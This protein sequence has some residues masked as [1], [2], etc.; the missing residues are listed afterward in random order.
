MIRLGGLVPSGAS[1]QIIRGQVACKRLAKTS[2]VQ[3]G[4]Q[5]GIFGTVGDAISFPAFAQHRRYGSIKKDA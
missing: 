2:M 3:Q 4:P 5:C 1:P